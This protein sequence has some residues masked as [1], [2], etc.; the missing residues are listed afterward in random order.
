MRARLEVYLA[1]F[2]ELQVRFVDERR[3]VEHPARIP[4][5][6]LAVREDAQFAIDQRIQL[7]EG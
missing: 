2:D 6:P 1:L 5:S 7:I 3:G 4:P